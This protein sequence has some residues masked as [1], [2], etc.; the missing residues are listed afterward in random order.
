VPTPNPIAAADPANPGSCLLAVKAVPGASRSQIA[1][2]LDLPEG[3]RLKV[4]IAAAPESGKANK[5]IEKL[6][7]NALKVSAKD[8]TLIAGPTNPIKTFRLRGLDPA[9]VLA[10]LGL[11]S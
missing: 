3:P 10:R 7:A 8:V 6:L 4:R 9:S 2:V 5:A 11:D 1:G